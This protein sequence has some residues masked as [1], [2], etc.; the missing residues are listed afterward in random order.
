MYF[1][2]CGNMYDLHVQHGVINQGRAR[3][4]NKVLHNHH[5]HDVARPLMPPKDRKPRKTARRE[6]PESLL[7]Q[8]I[9]IK[10][11]GGSYSAITKL[12]KIPKST[13]ANAW[14]RYEKTGQVRPT[15]RTG[16]PKK[17]TARDD[18]QLLI[19][20]RRERGVPYEQLRQNFAVQ[21]SARTIRRRLD[22]FGVH[23]HITAERPKPTPY[24]SS[25]MA[26][27]SGASRL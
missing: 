2:I 12:T 14:A 9:G 7:W 22:A 17:T 4:G 3:G 18:R 10:R 16:R 20:S 25:T 15:I 19:S 27:F 26:R 11:V 23:K 5:D 13:V 6:W 1:I 24:R 21:I 8:A